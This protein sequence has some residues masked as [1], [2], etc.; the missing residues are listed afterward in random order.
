M[1]P[2]TDAAM[3][4][5]NQFKGCLLGLA[6]GDAIGAPFEGGI[7]ERTVWRI[8]GVTKRSEMRWTDDT[9]MAV[10]VVESF[11]AKEELD[12]DDLS[13]R[14][15][16][17]Y[18]WSRG[19]GPAAAKTLKRIR[20]GVPW[21]LANRSV[22]PGGSFGN[23]AAMR[24]PIVGLIYAKRPEALVSAA[25][26]VASVTH[27]HELGIEGA[28]LLAT[29]TELGARGCDSCE[30]IQQSLQLFS[31]DA[32]R[33]RLS[34]ALT[35]LKDEEKPAAVEVARKLGR[36]IAAHE[37]CVTAVYLAL[38]FRQSPFLDLQHFVVSVGGDVDTIGAM[39]GAVWGVMNG[40]D[41]LPLP[42]LSTL[43][44]RDRLIDLAT[45]L[46]SKVTAI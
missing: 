10:D 4:T 29:A 30:M 37:S 40:F 21:K 43:E 20:R 33:E 16:S 11:L 45:S 1:A 13:M 39:A 31:L 32:F 8:I 41:N 24:S 25:R 2:L 27:A 18:R 15:A 5:L 17:S 36:G 3:P 14:F 12:P 6:L 9:Q 46:H 22:Y 38:R 26:Q 44:Q 23:G 42:A 19:Y 28:I 34:T 35:W 7:V